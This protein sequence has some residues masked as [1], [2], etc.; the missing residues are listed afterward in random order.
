MFMSFALPVNVSITICLIAAAPAAAHSPASCS[1]LTRKKY[2][3]S[4]TVVQSVAIWPH[5]IIRQMAPLP[6]FYTA[7]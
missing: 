7:T 4:Q 2:M 5:E 1:C 6:G 3:L